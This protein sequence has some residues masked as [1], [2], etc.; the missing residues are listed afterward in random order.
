MPDRTR[1]VDSRIVVV[2]GAGRDGPD[3]VARQDKPM[4]IDFRVL[5]TAKR[6]IVEYDGHY[7]VER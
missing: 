6:T 7:A 5:G 4:E 2:C 1:V 3:D